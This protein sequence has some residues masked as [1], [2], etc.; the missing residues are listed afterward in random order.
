MAQTVF[1]RR[2]RSA[3]FQ[4]C[5]LADFE[6]AGAFDFS[7]RGI[8][9]RQCGFADLRHGRLGSLPHFCCGSDGAQIHRRS[10]TKVP[11]VTARLVKGLLLALTNPWLLLVEWD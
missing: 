7:K 11:R 2:Y 9:Y 8:W 3:G 4:T 10:L 1:L 6:S 5:W